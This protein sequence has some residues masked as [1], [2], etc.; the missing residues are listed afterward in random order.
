MNKLYPALPTMPLK[1]G[2]GYFKPT[3]PPEI[4]HWK[5]PAVQAMIDF[6]YTKVAV[7]SE[8]TSVDAA[9][10]AVKNTSYHV[11]LVTDAE[12]HVVGI[13]GAEDLLGEKPVKA[14]QQRRLARAD[15]TVNMVMTPRQE[16][17]TLNFEDLRHSKVGHIIETLHTH[18]Q[19]YALVIAE[20]NHHGTKIRGLFS[21]AFLS[22]QLG[23]DVTGSGA[24]AQ[25]IA[26]LQHDLHLPE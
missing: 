20:D 6:K 22:K 26:E 2:I 17:L 10:L 4:V 1:S 15:I 13:V 16:T 18:K 23:Q 25:S 5:D 19:H 24:E 3:E 14:I 8:E 21:S 12:Q 9:L 7:V 11:L